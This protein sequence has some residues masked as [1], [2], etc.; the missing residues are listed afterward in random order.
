MTEAIASWSVESD[1]MPKETSGEKI[2]E[3]VEKEHTKDD[4]KMSD[5]GMD[6]SEGSLSS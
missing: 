2:Q 6:G 3:A 4:S 1:R 5:D